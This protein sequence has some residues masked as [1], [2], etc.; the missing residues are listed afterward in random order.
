MLKGVVN[1]DGSTDGLI[2]DV[3]QYLDYDQSGT[4]TDCTADGVQA[5][6][7]L[8]D[9]LQNNGRK[10]LLSETGG[11][12]TDSCQTDLCAQFDAMNNRS[13]VYLGWVGWAAGSFDTDYE[14]AQTPTNS[15][16]SWTDTSIVS[17]CVA[18]KFGASYS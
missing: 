4:H 12:N 2:F 14:L 15:G 17:A 11:G 5:I 1:P 13:D 9:W 3:H 7:D 16:S 8:A 6:N 10:A 18:G